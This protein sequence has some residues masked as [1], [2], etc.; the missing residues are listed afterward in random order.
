VLDKTQKVRGKHATAKLPVGRLDA[1]NATIS[2][3]P[4]NDQPAPPPIAVKNAQF[5]VDA[6]EM[7]RQLHQEPGFFTG[8]NGAATAGATLVSAT[9]NS[10]AFSGSL[11]LV[12]VVPTVT[13]LDSRNRTSADF[14]ESFGKITQPAYTTAAGPVAAS[15]T[16]SSILHFDAERDQYFSPRFY[17]LA[18]TSFDHNFSQ[19]LDLQQIYG[20]GIGWTA[21]K[22][23]TQS[24]DIKGTM[25]YERQTFISGTS[26]ENQSLIG[27]TF[28]GSYMLKLKLVTFAQSVSFIPAWN[29]VRAY[30]T[31]ETNTFTFPTYKNFGLTVGTMDSYLND[32]P[33]TEPPTKRNSF[34]F[35]TGVTYAF[36]SK[37]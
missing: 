9:Q 1:T 35:T 23:A 16:K 34:Q 25:Q 26:S 33:P 10:Y 18:Q 21:I 24:A 36:K 6:G 15:V 20:G 17:A 22:R 28:A 12:R 29:N 30:S 3:Q 11:G 8:W 32:P 5:I 37:Y 19:D 2:V 31:E 27:S 13:W 7:D 4:V 14:N